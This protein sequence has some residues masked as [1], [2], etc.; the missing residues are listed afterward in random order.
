MKV[1]STDDTTIFGLRVEEKPLGSD[2]A[3]P[4][5]YTGPPML[6]DF[7]IGNQWL[8]W[9]YFDPGITTPDPV[10]HSISVNCESGYYSYASFFVSIFEKPCFLSNFTL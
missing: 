9:V 8:A 7:N 2:P 3:N 10:T 4:L 6:L 5:V 1:T